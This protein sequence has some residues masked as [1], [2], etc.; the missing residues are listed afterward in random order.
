M[1]QAIRNRRSKRFQ[2]PQKN[3]RVAAG[4]LSACVRRVGVERFAFVCVDPAKHRSYWMMTDFLGNVLLAPDCVEHNAGALQAAVSMVRRKMQ[5]A[6]IQV[7][8]VIV[9]RTGNYHLPVQR[10]FAAA[11]FE[12]RVL[13]PFATKQYRQV[14]DPGNKTDPTDL[15]AQ[16]RAAVAGFG[17][18]ELPLDEDYRRLR[19]LAR[20]RRDL[21]QKSSV[22][23]SQLRE[24]L[25]LVMPGY[26]QCFENL[27]LS[28]VALP[29][30]RHAGTPQAVLERGL[31]G[32]GECLRREGLRFQTSTLQRVLA[33]AR[34]ASP[35][36]ADS[37]LH[38]QI[39]MALDDDRLGKCREIEA[40]ERDLA[41]ALVR[42][43]YVLLLAFPG[44][45]V[46]SAAE[47]AGE[48][49]PVAHYGNP[50]SVT[51]RA[52]L[53]P[54][55]YQSDQVDLPDGPL[56]R[57]ANRRLRSALM[58]IA[59]NLVVNNHFFHSQADLQRR[60]K[61]DE[62]VIRVRV[63]KKF[64]RLAY[65]VLAGRQVLRHAC[66]QPG[67][68]VLTKLS[69]FHRLHHTPPAQLMGDLHATVDQLPRNAYTREAQSL[70]DQLQTATG[71]RRGPAL[72]GDLLPG[73]LARLTAKT[74]EES[75]EAQAS[76]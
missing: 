58:R 18:I 68:A 66:C 64:T 42:T 53:F 7:V 27:W 33:W 23:C 34:Q 76:T 2:S 10:A 48:M 55:R 73:V 49:G 59:D 63:A 21:V 67:D 17:L 35:P 22:L 19:L 15:A 5:Q 30:A 51:G 62:R 44:I 57:R 71:H 16:H 52:G 74:T 37:S 47:L 14:A 13:H 31:A 32:L 39:W 72:L 65:A 6:D 28:V 45:N 46:V 40:L 36:D 56:V 24:H 61:I 70:S 38:Q 11:G 60:Q 9:E 12:T 25:H 4:E 41:A 43:P 29:I 8:W 75:S 50:N 54:S 69:T 20:H 26:A 1:V 3:L